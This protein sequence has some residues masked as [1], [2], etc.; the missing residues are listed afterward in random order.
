MDLKVKV[1]PL[2]GNIIDNIFFKLPDRYSSSCTVLIFYKVQVEY[3][4]Y[5]VYA[6]SGERPYLDSV[7]EAFFSAI[8]VGIG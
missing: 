2:T 5:R 3:H 4:Q 8:V 7:T 6:S 1:E